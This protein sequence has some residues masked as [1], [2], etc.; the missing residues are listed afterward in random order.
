MDYQKNGEEDEKPLLIKQPGSSGEALSP[1]TRK[2]SG[3]SAIQ[4]NYAR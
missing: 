3:L 4:I 2:F 1:T